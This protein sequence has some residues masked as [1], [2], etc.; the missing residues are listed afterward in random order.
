MEEI[1]WSHVKGTNYWTC[2]MEIDEIFACLKDVE[3]GGFVA[4]FVGRSSGV[5]DQSITI[6]SYPC[7]HETL[8]DCW[9]GSSECIESSIISCIKSW[10]WEDGPIILFS[11]GGSI[12]AEDDELREVFD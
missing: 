6:D 12:I 7:E 11:P 8:E 10:D 9:Y 2:G 5:V 4:E 3:G 1:T